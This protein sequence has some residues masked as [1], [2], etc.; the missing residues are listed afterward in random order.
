M[1]DE[2]QHWVPK[3]LVKNFAD[4]D[5]R[6]YRLNILDDETTKVPP[7]HAASNLNFNQFLI[8][9]K[10]VSFERELEKIETRAAPILK[11][12]ASSHSIVGLKD[13]QRSLV[14]KFM[15]A[16]SFRTEAFFKDALSSK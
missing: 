8:D 1:S 10:P 12:I 15:A 13:K 16:Q 7:K 11:R 2:N 9:G 14:A 5:G 3:F 4:V 6:V